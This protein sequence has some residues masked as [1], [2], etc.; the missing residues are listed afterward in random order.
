MDQNLAAVSLWL[1]DNTRMCQR[2]RMASD[3]LK[4]TLYLK[5][6]QNNLQLVLFIHSNPPHLVFFPL[7]FTFWVTGFTHKLLVFW[8][9]WHAKYRFKPKQGPCQWNTTR[10]TN[11][12][13]YQRE[14]GNVFAVGRQEKMHWYLSTAAHRV[15]ISQEMS[16]GFV[17]Q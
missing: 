3:C 9:W 13:L 2:L 11:M 16:W 4:W 10:A 17:L 6:R 15:K 12:L 1:Q 8:Q 14:G 5:S 7:L